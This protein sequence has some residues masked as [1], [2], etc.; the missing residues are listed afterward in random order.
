MKSWIP[1]NL[2]SESCHS[3]LSCSRMIN[4]KSHIG[5]GLE[6]TIQDQKIHLV[7]YE[8]IDSCNLDQAR[9]HRDDAHIPSQSG[10]TDHTTCHISPIHG[11][12]DAPEL[13][14][15]EF[16]QELPP[17]EG[18]DPSEIEETTVQTLQQVPIPKDTGG[19]DSSGSSFE[20]VEIDLISSLVL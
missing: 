3:S 18:E 2:L 13:S 14:L 5:Q 17:I 6:N 9:H 7:S 16:E 12:S 10:A 19:L 11:Q 15:D 8:T 1:T 4:D 20:E